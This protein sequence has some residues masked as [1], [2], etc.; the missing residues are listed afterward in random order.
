MRSA[1]Q[2][3]LSGV[4]RVLAILIA[5]LSALPFLYLVAFTHHRGF[6]TSEA[7]LA[8]VAG[9][10]MGV[11]GYLYRLS[12]RLH[13]ASA[14][15]TPSRDQRAPVL[16]L[17]AFKDDERTS[18]PDASAPSLLSE[19]TT[20]EE[21]LAAALAP[22]GPVVAIGVPGEKLPTLGATREYVDH[23]KWQQHV[24]AYL[25]NSVLVVLRIANTKN[26]F[27]EFAETIREVSPDRILLL[28]PGP[29]EYDEFRKLANEARLPVQLPVYP[30]Y[31]LRRRTFSEKIEEKITSKLAQP[32][33]NLERAAKGQAAVKLTPTTFGFVPRWAPFTWSTT[34]II[35]FTRDG[36][37]RFA[38]LF[39]PK[40][41]QYNIGSAL[42][43]AMRPIFEQIGVEWRPASLAWGRTLWSAINW[44][45]VIAVVAGLLIIVLFALKGPH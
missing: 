35:Y 8:G 16:Y 5:A 17:R 23:D 2:A 1:D 36:T 33:L 13:A 19:F 12:K 39:V 29:Q 15:Q 3:L 37:P 41:R 20:E 40:W 26:L 42:I 10:T 28:V 38:P 25:K 31:A 45:I 21:H 7:M 34:A 6:N 44:T 18:H 43:H 32:V 30:G 27:W 9:V 14:I 11:A 22:L 24:Q 4:L